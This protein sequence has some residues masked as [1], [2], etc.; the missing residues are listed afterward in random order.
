MAKPKLGGIDMYTAEQLEQMKAIIRQSMEEG[1][2]GISTGLIYTPSVYAEVNES[3]ELAKV[4][5][6]YKGIY[7]THIRGENDTVVEAV[8]EAL[9][10]GRRAKIPVQ[11]SHLKAMG[12]H[13]WGTSK[14]I[15]KMIDDAHAE[16]WMPSYLLGLPLAVKPKW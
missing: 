3:T 4:A 8:A 16:A 5:A 9:E 11:I 6:E 7:F 12:K 15:L 13:M 10:I 14:T 2:F 1:S